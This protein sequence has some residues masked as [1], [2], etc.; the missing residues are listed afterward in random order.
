MLIE[1]AVKHNQ[2]TSSQVLKIVIACDNHNISVSNNKTAKPK[3]VDSFKIGL[4]NIRSRYDL[5]FNKTIEVIDDEQ[6]TV[7]LPIIL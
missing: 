2:M 7:K 3:G 6:F 1:N 5:I 4:S